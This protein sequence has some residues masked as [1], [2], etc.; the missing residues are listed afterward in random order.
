MYSEFGIQTFLKKRIYSVDIRSV[1]T[2]CDNTGDHRVTRITG[3][4]PS[5]DTDKSGQ[6]CDGNQRI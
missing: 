5:A 6:N 2:I 1:L 4:L 3:H